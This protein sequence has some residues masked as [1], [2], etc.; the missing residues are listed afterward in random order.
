MD[1]LKGIVT[2]CTMAIFNDPC[3]NLF[4]GSHPVSTPEQAIEIG[5]RIMKRKYP[6]RNLGRYEIRLGDRGDSWAVFY[7]LIDVNTGRMLKGGGG[8]S[9]T[10]RKS[11]GKIITSEV[12]QR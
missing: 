8:P 3:I 9:V 11:D 12:S 10:I 1:I 4:S 2:L 6:F 5:S 7:A